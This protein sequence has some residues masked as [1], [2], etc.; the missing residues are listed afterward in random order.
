MS[1]HKGLHGH[2]PTLEKYNTTQK[3]IFCIQSYIKCSNQYHKVLN[4]PK[5]EAAFST[6]KHITFLL[7]FRYHF[8]LFT[9]RL[10]Q[11]VLLSVLDA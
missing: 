6:R 9:L 10:L 2:V 8:Q 5:K 1:Q 11:N 4:E 7:P 3:K